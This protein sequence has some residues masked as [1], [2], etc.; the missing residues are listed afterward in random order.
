MEDKGGET[1]ISSLSDPVIQGL[2][3]GLWLGLCLVARLLRESV[4]ILKL[5]RLTPGY[6]RLLQSQV[7]GEVQMQGQGSLVNPVALM[8]A[9]VGIGVSLYSARRMSHTAHL[10]QP[11]A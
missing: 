6:F 2:F 8:M 1:H 3:R 10:K 9:S 5:G 7:S 4:M 11:A